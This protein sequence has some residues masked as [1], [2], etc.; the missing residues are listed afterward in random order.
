MAL[1]N[2]TPNLGKALLRSK[3]SLPRVVRTLRHAG[4][5]LNRPVATSNKS[6]Q[7]RHGHIGM[8]RPGCK[9]FLNHFI[10]AKL[11]Q[12]ISD[13]E[14]LSLYTDPASKTIVEK[15]V[16][17]TTAAA[18]QKFKDEEIHSYQNWSKDSV[19]CKRGRRQVTRH[20]SPFSARNWRSHLPLRGWSFDVLE[21]ENMSLVMVSNSLS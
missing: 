20:A 8:S 1:R 13:S 7:I 15:Y 10:H 11:G 3:S 19:L 9:S 4:L 5:R 2:S 18:A 6:F 21:R 17:E 12:L 14:I 16:Q